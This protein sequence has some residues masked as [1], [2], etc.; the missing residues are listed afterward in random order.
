VSSQLKG[1]SQVY[2]QALLVWLP[3]KVEGVTKLLE[4]AMELI[5]YL[6]VIGTSK[7]K[8]FLCLGLLYMVDPT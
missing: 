6:I 1:L 7:N 8:V 2:G 3:E 4:Q 5:M